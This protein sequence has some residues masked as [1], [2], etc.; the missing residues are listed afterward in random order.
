[1][2]AGS[3]FVG[4]GRARS[5]SRLG[6]SQGEIDATPVKAQGESEKLNLQ[7]SHHEPLILQM[8]AGDRQGT[9]RKGLGLVAYLAPN[10][11]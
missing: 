7:A 10:V 4:S 3:D 11:I 2:S 1:M 6:C 9:L 8:R 5:K